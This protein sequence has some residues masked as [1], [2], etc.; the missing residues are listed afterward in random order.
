MTLPRVMVVEDDNMVRMLLRHTLEEEG[1]PVEA[2][3]HSEEA[4]QALKTTRFPIILSDLRLPGMD[5]LALLERVRANFPDTVRILITA[6][7]NTAT[8]ATAI[9]RGLLFRYL[10]KPWTHEELLATLKSAAEHYELEQSNARLRRE[11]EELTQSLRIAKNE[12][13]ILNHELQAQVAHKQAQVESLERMRAELGSQIERTLALCYQLQEKND[14][15]LAI[16]TKA[17]VDIC[18]RLSRAAPLSEA[19]AHCL[20]TSA[21]L[22]DLG[23]FGIPPRILDVSRKSMESLNNDE[24]ARIESHPMVSQQLAGLIDS[25]PA[26]SACIRAHHERHDGSGYP[27]KLAGER[28]PEMARVLSIVTFL[29]ENPQPHAN[30]LRAIERG[31]GNL[32]HPDAVRFVFRYGDV[33]DPPQLLSEVVFDELRPGMKLANSLYGPTGLL[34]VAKDRVLDAATIEHIHT[35]NRLNPLHQR[36]FIYR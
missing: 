9:N 15:V 12:L 5:G 7:G 24:R 29:T 25:N 21:W 3:R 22:C 28:I 1:Y 17:R 20:L 6:Y 8:L 14:P 30:T 36:I 4:L 23:L 31:A 2:F 35:Y 27:D 33:T 34:L 16:H 32:F 26:I 10:S 13:Q 11:K 19:D 18:R